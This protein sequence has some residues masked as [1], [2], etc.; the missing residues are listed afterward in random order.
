MFRFE[1][2]NKVRKSN[3]DLD[4]AITILLETTEKKEA[5]KRKKEEEER[6]KREEEERKKKE[7]QKRR[8]E[9]RKRKE[10]L[11]KKQ[12][13]QTFPEEVIQQ[14]FTPTTLCLLTSYSLGDEYSRRSH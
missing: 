11:E 6:K 8:D 2:S 9:E 4:V 7:E 14:V 12:Q 1:Y 5:E 3:L 13:E 10:E